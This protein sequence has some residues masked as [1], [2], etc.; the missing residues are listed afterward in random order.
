[1]R[2]RCKNADEGVVLVAIQIAVDSDLSTERTVPPHSTHVQLGDVSH[3]LIQQG[4]RER[5]RKT[6]SSS[7]TM[8]WW[9]WRSVAILR[10]FAKHRGRG[11]GREVGL[12]QGEVKTHLL[13]APRPSS[14]YRGRG[15]A[16]PPPRVPPLGAAASPNPSRVRPRGGEGE[17]A[18]QVRWK[19]PLPKP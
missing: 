16:A 18:P 2:K 19:H 10:G 14:I 1:M 13:A 5:L 6:P 12:R 9:W 8:V 17:L 11:E 3:A 7:S 4:E 15:R